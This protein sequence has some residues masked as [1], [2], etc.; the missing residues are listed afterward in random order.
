M[1]RVIIERQISEGSIDDYLELSRRARKRANTIKGFIA[2]ELLQE[3]DNP[4]LAVIISS[5][6]DI[7]SWNKWSDAKERLEIMKEMR[8]LLSSDERVVVLENSNIL[9]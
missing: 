7:E 4:N 5:W 3:K 6:E 9:G 1:I 2:G 8:P